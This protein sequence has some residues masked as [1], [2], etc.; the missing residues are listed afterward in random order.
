MESLSCSITI[1]VIVQLFIKHS[2]E[3]PAFA[4]MTHKS[5]AVTP[6]NTGVSYIGLNCY[7]EPNIDLKKPK[8]K[9]KGI[10]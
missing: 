2:M 7:E 1:V 3:I 6:V 10:S 5:I 4:G 8:G 9:H